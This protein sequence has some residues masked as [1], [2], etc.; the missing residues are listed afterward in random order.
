MN[1]FHKRGASFGI[2]LIVS[3][4]VMFNVVL[5]IGQYSIN[6]MA[7]ET[8]MVAPT[9]AGSNN[10]FMKDYDKGNGSYVLNEEYASKLP[11]S[12]GGVLANLGVFL[13]PLQVFLSWLS[14]GGTFIVSILSAF[15]NFLQGMGLPPA[16]AF[17]GGVAWHAITLFMLIYAILK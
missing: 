6:S 7:Q 5:W 4:V 10:Q 2:M 3:F 9:L 1:T 13:F 14:A 11:Q 12:N 16:I 15:P 8:G 17:A